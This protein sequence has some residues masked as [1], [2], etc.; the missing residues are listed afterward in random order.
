VLSPGIRNPHHS[1]LISVAILLLSLASIAWGV[2]DMQ[3]EGKETLG[4]GLKIGLALLPAI[5]APF[6]ILNFWGGMRVIAAIRRGDNVFAR[7]TVT[8]AELAVFATSN[9]ARNALGSD[10]LND[11]APPRDQPASTVEVKFT[12]SAV[13]VGDTYFSLTT[14]GPYR[15]THAWMH[16]DGT[17]AVAFR[18]LVTSAN[19]FGMRTTAGELRI[20]VS[21]SAAAEAPKVV[22]HFERVRA[23]EVIANPDFYRRRMKIGL[24]GAPVFFVIA[25]LGFMLGP[26][27][28]AKGDISVASLMAIVGLVFGVGMLILALAAF[29]LDAKRSKR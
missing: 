5:L 26:K 9:K 13:L 10:H 11:W 14:T 23:G 20:P 12:P 25:A 28:V 1:V 15:F 3:A 7:W 2:M 19:R 27:D 17:P 4:S 18:T 16:A 21:Q 8:A 29:A 22:A 24:I 6:L